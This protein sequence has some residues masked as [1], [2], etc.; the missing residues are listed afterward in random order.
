MLSELAPGRQGAAVAQRLGGVARTR[1]REMPPGA[2][3][4]GSMVTQDDGQVG[5]VGGP[6][7]MLRG[8][9][10]RYGQQEIETTVQAMVEFIT[11]RRL[12][13]ESIDDAISR[14]ETL[15]V[16][17]EQLG[18]FTMSVP[19]TAFQLLQQLHVPKSVWPLILVPFNNTL[20]RTEYDLQQ[21][22][23]S[24]RRQAHL[25]EHTHSGPRDLDEGFRRPGA[26]GHESSSHQSFHYAEE[27]Q[28][29][30]VLPVFLLLFFFLG[31]GAP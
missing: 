22:L 24:V 17:A 3:R 15:R 14:F 9:Q 27:E 12:Q 23:Q 6:Q 8:L 13:S 20:P 25:V 18:E 10:R 5:H 21:L 30:P 4:D 19:A 31:G 16:R 28:A 1:V 7:L 26:V 29:T 11:Y 2:L